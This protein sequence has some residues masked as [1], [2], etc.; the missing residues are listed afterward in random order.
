[1]FGIWIGDFLHTTPYADLLPPNNMFL[2]HPISFLGRYIEVYQMH[3]EYVSAQ[4]AERR[5]NKV[6]DVKKRSDYRKA[7]G[8]AQGEGIFG[9]WSA[10]SDDENIGPAL[11]TDRS[12]RVDDASPQATV[13]VDAAREDTVSGAVG[14]AKEGEEV[15]V[16]FDGKK[17]AAPKKWFGIW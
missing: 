15:F 14:G 4:T 8:I 10:K 7:H 17:Q 9:G 5:K 6:D 11:V 16:D 3:V 1:V 13:K 12:S 2:S